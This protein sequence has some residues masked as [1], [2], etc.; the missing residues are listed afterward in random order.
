MKTDLRRFAP[1]GLILSLLAALSFIVILIVK[2]LAAGGIFTLPDPKVLDQSLWVCAGI[3]ILG[4]AI[5]AFLDPERARNF[6]LGRQLHYG[7]NSIIM[8]LAFLGILLFINM[9]VYQYSSTS[10]PWDW[11]EDKKN[12]LAP[13][14]LDM[15]KALPAP[16]TVRA[17]FLNGA[18]ETVQTLLD[19]F[20]QNSNGKLTYEVINPNYDPIKAQNDGVTSDGTI[21]AI[22][23]DRKEI[24]TYTAEQELD[25]AILKLINPKQLSLYFLTG[26][27]ERDS[28]DAG[29]FAGMKT[30]LKNKNYTTQLLNLSNQRA[31]PEDASVVIIAGPQVPLTADET[32]VLETYLGKGGALIVMKDP[33]PFT[34]SSGSTADP[35]DDLL[36]KWGITLQND[37]IIDTNA[38]N[39]LNA[40]VDTQ[41]LDQ[42]HP[43]TKKMKGY[44]L[45][46]NTARSLK[47]ADIA[48]DGITLTNLAKTFPGGGVA[49]VWGET[50]FKSI[51]DRNPE[52]DP[53]SDVQ[54]PLTLAASAENIT[55][56]GRLVVFGD[57]DF[58]SDD[59]RQQGF[60]DIL[61]NSVDWSA[62]QENV[63]SLTPKNNIERS[64]MIPDTL[65]TIA[66]LLLSVCGIPLLVVVAGAW[67]WYSRRRRG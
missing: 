16:V 61:V 31:V 30:V 53:N 13:E 58:A 57:S 64:F 11:T 65:T 45:L 54:A 33:Q 14:T 7:S 3:L 5:T 4:L 37:I 2:G 10:T 19:N 40:V 20:K 60:G 51:E 52:M 12:S 55:T 1:L 39:A 25:A 28:Q 47:L 32:A 63:I 38:T 62:Q 48:P 42:F 9:M 35:L 21:I 23:G 17:Y 49:G 50:N 66:S 59:Y 8:L 15:L 18:D 22:M 36:T 29:D 24:V 26:H 41:T 67:A 46:F 44:T 6:F 27:G 56:K 34:K 43:I